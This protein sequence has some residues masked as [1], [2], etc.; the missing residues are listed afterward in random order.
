MNPELFKADNWGKFVGF[1]KKMGEGETLIGVGKKWSVKLSIL[2]M[3][4]SL[5]FKKLQ[6]LSL[7]RKRDCGMVRPNGLCLYAM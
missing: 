3:L 2:C 6:W 7:T 1:V 4:L 5:W